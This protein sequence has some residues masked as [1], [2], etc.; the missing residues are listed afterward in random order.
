MDTYKMNLTLHAR[1]LTSALL[2]GL[3]VGLGSAQAQSQLTL[4]RLMSAVPDHANR[5]QPNTRSIAPNTP[6]APEYVTRTGAVMLDVTQLMQ[7]L[8]PTARQER[9]PDSKSVSKFPTA[10]G[11]TFIL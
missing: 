6:D 2:A 11:E 4:P 9:A 3:L 10:Q 5:S 8:T 1:R 7:R